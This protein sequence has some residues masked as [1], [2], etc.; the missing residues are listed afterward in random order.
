MIAVA[1]GRLPA[2]VT[3]PSTVLVGH[4]RHLDLTGADDADTAATIAAAIT[5]ATAFDLLV[6]RVVLVG[7]AARQVH[8]LAMMTVQLMMSGAAVATT[9]HNFGIC[10]VVRHR[11]TSTTRRPGAD[12]YFTGVVR[13]ASSDGVAER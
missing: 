5:T 9:V 7:E 6:H 11:R 2:H 8:V 13:S 1:P 12:V 10:V 4:I 3:L